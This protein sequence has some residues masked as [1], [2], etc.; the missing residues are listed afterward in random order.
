MNDHGKSNYSCF[1]NTYNACNAIYQKRRKKN[2]QSKTREA[3]QNEI[4][5]EKKCYKHFWHF[6][7]TPSMFYMCSMFIQLSNTCFMA[8]TL[9][10]YIKKIWINNSS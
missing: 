3:R 9:T 2:F 5:R 6:P 4:G 10:K 8:P 7:T 1:K